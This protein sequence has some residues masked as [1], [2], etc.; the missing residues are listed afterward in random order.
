MGRAAPKPE[1]ARIMFQESARMSWNDIS[2]T[3]PWILSLPL[4]IA[5]LFNSRQKGELISLTWTLKDCTF[6]NPQK[7]KT[8]TF[9]VLHVFSQDFHQ[10]RQTSGPFSFLSYLIKG[11]NEKEVQ[12]PKERRAV[13]EERL[14]Y[15]SSRRVLENYVTLL[16]FLTHQFLR[17]LFAKV[18]NSYL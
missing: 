7:R 6:L 2:Q 3:T 1:A 17:K 12:F 10:K 16:P 11:P 18:T 15:P 9:S 13:A 14:T 5:L 4:L 8:D